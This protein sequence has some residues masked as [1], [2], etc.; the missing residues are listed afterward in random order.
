MKNEELIDSILNKYTDNGRIKY[1]EIGDH[2]NFKRRYEWYKE[3]LIKEFP[4]LT[5]GEIVKFHKVFQRFREKVYGF[6]GFDTALT[7]LE[8]EIEYENTKN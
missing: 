1:A 8:K 6:N 7:I 4:E 3:Y 5:L 2:E